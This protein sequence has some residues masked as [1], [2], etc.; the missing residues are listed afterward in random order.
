MKST[1]FISINGLT[2]LCASSI[3]S[4]RKSTCCSSS[5]EATSST[6]AAGLVRKCLCEFQRALLLQVAVRCIG[7]LEHLHLRDCH[8][9]LD[10][11]ALQY[12]G[13]ETGWPNLCLQLDTPI[14]ANV[15]ILG[16][17]QNPHVVDGIAAQRPLSD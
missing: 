9:D 1:D 3:D 13:L 8:L 6:M 12:L 15:I 10:K 11:R 17:A 16:P 4:N 7:L 14:G 2:V 5:F